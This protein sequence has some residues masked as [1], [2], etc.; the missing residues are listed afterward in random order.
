MKDPSNG[1]CATGAALVGPTIASDTPWHRR[2][3]GHR[4]HRHCR[5]ADQQGAVTTSPRNRRFSIYTVV[6][7]TGSP[8]R[9]LLMAFDQQTPYA[10]LPEVDGQPESDRATADDD[11]VIGCHRGGIRS[12]PS[13]R[14]TSPFRKPLRTICS[15]SAAYSDG[16]PRRDGK[17]M[18]A[19]RLACTSGGS[20]ST[21]GV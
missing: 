4:G 20:P 1:I 16:R 10:G 3:P 21:I 2:Q 13:S 19:P 7:S 5:A 14:I 8:P 17:G 6:A 15:T 18:P 11:D 12:A 9:R